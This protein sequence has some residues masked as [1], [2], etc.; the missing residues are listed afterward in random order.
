VKSLLHRSGTDALALACWA[1]AAF[2][3]GCESRFPDVDG[4]SDLTCD[5]LPGVCSMDDG[6][7]VVTFTAESCPDL[8]QVIETACPDAETVFAV[9]GV[10]GVYVSFACKRPACVEDCDAGAE[11]GSVDASKEHGP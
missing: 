9:C 6:S 8:A 1:V 7:A 11:A 2:A 5:A 10:G 4:G 3:L